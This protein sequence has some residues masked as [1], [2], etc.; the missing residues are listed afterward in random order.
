MLII[1]MHN[2]PSA[3]SAAMCSLSSKAF[4]NQ[5]GHLGCDFLQRID[6]KD[7]TPLMNSAKAL[8]VFVRPVACNLERQLNA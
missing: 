8:L 3:R 6:A 2:Q 4:C 1:Y 5:A 7:A